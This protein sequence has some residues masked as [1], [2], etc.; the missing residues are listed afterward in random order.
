VKKTPAAMILLLICLCVCLAQEVP[1]K[2]PGLLTE[3]QLIE[4]LKG[5]LPEARIKQFISVCG[6]QFSLD[7][8]TEARLRA[9]GATTPIIDLIRMNQ[10][11]Q[12]SEEE[13]Q[14]RRDQAQR[15]ERQERIRILAEEIKGSAEHGNWDSVERK[16]DDLLNYD[17]NN[18]TATYWKATAGKVIS[19]KRDLTERMEARDW[20]GALGIIVELRK[21]VPNDAAVILQYHD[22][23]AREYLRNREPGKAI[24]EVFV[25]GNSSPCESLSRYFKVCG[26]AEQVTE[27][28]AFVARTVWN[29][30]WTCYYVLSDDGDLVLF[31]DSNGATLRVYEKDVWFIDKINGDRDAVLGRKNDSFP[32][33]RLHLQTSEP[34]INTLTVSGWQIGKKS[35]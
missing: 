12:P 9:A 26:K 21:I 14:A 5:E 31:D 32:S 13:M 20:Q 35:R 19:L 25:S 30:S 17:Q 11:R 15:L 33:R 24:K 6:L 22:L 29:L 8:E 18:S 7:A 28:Q 16:C 2:C 4:L 1:V 3:A 23:V 10:A 27:G 34:L